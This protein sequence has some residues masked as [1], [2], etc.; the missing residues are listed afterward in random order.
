MHY[1]LSLKSKEQTFWRTDMYIEFKDVSERDMDMLIIEE[2]ICNDAFR[3]LFYTQEGIKLGRDFAVCEAYKSLSDNDGESDVTFVVSD[4]K[5]RVAILVEDKIDACAQEEQ[6]QRYER[7]AQKGIENGKYDEYYIFLVCPGDYWKDHEKDKNAQYKYKV[8]YENMRDLYVGENNPRD[9]YKYQVIQTAIEAKKK[10][11]QVVENTAITQFWKEL[12]PYCE[13]RYPSLILY[14]K[15]T[16]KGSGSYWMEFQT[17]LKKTKIIYKSNKGCVDL[18]IGAYGDKI[19]TLTNILENKKIKL[20][21]S[22]GIYKA[23]GSAAIRMWKPEWAISFEQP[24]DNVRDI[25]DDVLK[26]VVRFKNLV[27]KLNETDLY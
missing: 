7:R 16:V 2:F 27:D 10:G 25:I 11:Y 6:S 15:D 3:D 26:T 18:Q 1:N 13:A 20:D 24:F 4:G 9:L 19:G 8:F 22:M 23:Q 17:P 14:G 12:R 5:T 21:K